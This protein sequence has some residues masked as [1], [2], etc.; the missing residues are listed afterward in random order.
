[1]RKQIDNF[2]A[3]CG[4][5]FGEKSHLCNKIQ[6]WITHINEY[7]NYYEDYLDRHKNFIVSVLNKIHCHVQR[8]LH[9]CARGWDKID[10]D[11]L[12]FSTIQRQ[13]VNETYFVDK[14]TWLERF[15]KT[16]DKKVNHRNKRFKSGDD[17]DHTVTEMDTN[18]NKDTRLKIPEGM[19]F[20]DICTKEARSAFNK[21]IRNEDNN[22]ICQK[23]HIK[24][25]CDSNC[26]MKATHKQLSDQ[27]ISEL[28]EFLSFAKNMK[29][30]KDNNKDTNRNQGNE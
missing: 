30:K 13:I 9:N 2:K 15:L 6:S 17:K 11:E 28:A 29:N 12:D 22:I 25:R 24:G 5:I 3:L 16:K 18:P 19:K 21:T 4:L 10:W 14:P 7:E 1:M 26:N 27:K 23:Y 20:G 8:H